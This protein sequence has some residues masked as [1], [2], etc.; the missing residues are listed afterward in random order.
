MNLPHGLYQIVWFPLM[1]VLGSIFGPWMFFAY[2]GFSVQ[3]KTYYGL[4][5]ILSAIAGAVGWCWRK[6]LI[7]KLLVVFGAAS[8]AVLGTIGFGTGT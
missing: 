8:W 7:G 3:E 4:A 1:M 5:L 2:P 6:K